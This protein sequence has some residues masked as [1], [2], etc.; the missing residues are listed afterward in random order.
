MGGQGKLEGM[1]SNVDTMA[2][3]LMA[4]SE[5]TY[6]LNSSEYHAE[7]KLTGGVVSES[8][9]VFQRMIRK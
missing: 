6:A 1:T 5:N 8:R 2:T 3:S 4:K 9:V 7:L